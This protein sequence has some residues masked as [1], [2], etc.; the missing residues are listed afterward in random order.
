[1]LGLSAT[2]QVN[3]RLSFFFTGRNVLNAPQTVWRT[4]IPGY[5]QANRVFGSNWTFGV[6]GTL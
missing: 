6:K 5:L 2:Y 1:M 3:Q 4:D